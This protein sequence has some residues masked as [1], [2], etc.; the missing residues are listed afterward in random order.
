M[1]S[2]PSSKYIGKE[3]FACALIKK[4]KYWLKFVPGKEIEAH[5]KEMDVGDTNAIKVKFDGFKY[6]IWGMKE[7][8]YVMQMMAMGG[9]LLTEG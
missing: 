1:S 4:R 2:R 6:N 9:T 7:P 5:F 3:F 8:N